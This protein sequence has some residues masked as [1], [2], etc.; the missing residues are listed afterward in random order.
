MKKKKKTTISDIAKELDITASTV[1]R[2]LKNHPRISDTT[3]KAVWKMVEKLNYQPNNIAAALRKGKSN[4]I[5]VIV[6]TSDRHFFASV[7]RGIEE[8]IRDEGY[9][10]IICQSDDQF[11]KEQL[12]IDALLQ[13][14]VDGIIASI[15]KE[16]TDISHFEKIKNRGVPLVLYDRVSESLDVNAVVTDDYLG[17]YKS[18]THLIEQGCKRIAHFAGHQHIN[19]YKDRLNG[20]LDAL[21]EH[22]LMIEDDLIIE[23]D[24]IKDTDRILNTGRE[25][26]GQLLQLSDPPDGVFSSS[27]FAAMGAIQLFKEKGI[28]IPEE[29]ALVGYSNDFSASVIEPSLTSV[30]QHT[31][32]MGNFAAQ[33]F[34]DQIKSKDEEFT[35]RKT[36]LN[37]KLVIRA[38]SSRIK[39]IES[40]YASESLSS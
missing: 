40:T 18:V 17:A 24:L 11:L 19:I 16:T 23:S 36:L 21:K 4:I 29:I 20:Y 22:D 5:G 37:P 3:K 28:K 12:N 35:P 39:K 26:G 1:S 2:A 6:P 33:L 7:I 30:D 10:L 9:N 38:S 34:L 8:V 27:D 25:I 13:I 15:A 31:K 14:Q 32:R